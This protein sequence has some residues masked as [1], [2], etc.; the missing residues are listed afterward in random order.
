MSKTSEYKFSNKE[1]ME[2]AREEFHIDLPIR[3]DKKEKQEYIYLECKEYTH[4]E[5]KSEYDKAR[6]VCL[7]NMI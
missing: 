2:M 5:N 3:K 7:L 4:M 6:L 1:V